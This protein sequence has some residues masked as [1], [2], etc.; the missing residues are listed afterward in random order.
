MPLWILIILALDALLVG[1][2]IVSEVVTEI[3]RQ[4]RAKEAHLRRFRHEG[5]SWAGLGQRPVPVQ[6][7]PW[8]KRL[9]S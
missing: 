5:S 9:F 7:A 1:V 2:L 8:W 3:Q 4:R 6:R